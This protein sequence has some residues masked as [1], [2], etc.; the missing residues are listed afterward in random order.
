MGRTSLSDTHTDRSY[1]MTRVY[2]AMTGRLLGHLDL[3]YGVHP[4]DCISEAMWEMTD[5]A[6][7]EFVS[8]GFESVTVRLR[9]GK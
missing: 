2:D 5:E 6:G 1:T 8:M 4:E 3:P 9:E 7:W